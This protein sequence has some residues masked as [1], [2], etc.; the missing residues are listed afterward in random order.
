MLRL[1]ISKTVLLSRNIIVDVRD[2]HT[3]TSLGSNEY[4]TEGREHDV[5]AVHRY[6]DEKTG[7]EVNELELFSLL[8][9]AFRDKFYLDYLLS[10][11]D[12]EESTLGDFND[13]M[14]EQFQRAS[15]NG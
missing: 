7:Q 8:G 1:N 3:V 12:G 13:L 11:K 6:I 15:H 2:I 5:V 14:F 10:K 9:D 4:G